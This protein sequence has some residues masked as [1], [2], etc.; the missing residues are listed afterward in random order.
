MF[1]LYSDLTLMMPPFFKN[2]AAKKRLFL[3][4]ITNVYSI[5]KEFYENS[6]SIWKLFNEMHFSK[7]IFQCVKSHTMTKTKW[8]P[9]EYVKEANEMPFPIIIY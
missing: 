2:S 7:N 9:S 3:N 5:L 8:R 4:Q 6:C 1:R